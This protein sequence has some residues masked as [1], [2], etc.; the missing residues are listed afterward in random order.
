MK[1]LIIEDQGDS[2]DIIQFGLQMFGFEVHTAE[3]GLYGMIEIYQYEPDVVLLE[4]NLPF[5]DGFAVLRQIKKD[6]RSAMIPVMIITSSGEPIL[7]HE[8][9]AA[10]AAD[11]LIK[12]V[13]LEIFG[14][15]AR[16]MADRYQLAK[17]RQADIRAASLL[18]KKFLTSIPQ[19]LDAFRNSKITPELFNQPATDISG[20]FFY[21]KPIRHKNAVGFFFADTCGHGLAAGLISMRILSGIE[22][23]DSPSQHPSE[24][25][26][27]INSDLVGIL[28]PGTFVA[29]LYC[30]FHENHVILSNAG[31]PAPIIIRENNA[32]LIEQYGNPLAISENVTF[33]DF[34][35]PLKSGDKFILYTDG[36]I[37]ATNPE[38][39]DYGLQ[40]L[41]NLCSAG[42]DHS[43]KKLTQTILEDLRL[44]CAGKPFDDDLSLAIF[45]AS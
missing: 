28:P 31:Q 35:I 4:L 36:L 27:F 14:A 12:P 37:E 22:T 29:A 38:D 11:Y 8:A 40:R 16:V 25:L 18:Q 15:R 2:R 24:L 23:V 26:H 7:Q 41:L 20:D 9:F 17:G 42:G 39:Q 5:T 33:D 13:D 44:F 3:N 32:T 43:A 10:G 19:L 21:P 6:L 34:T 45:T 1:A 30:I